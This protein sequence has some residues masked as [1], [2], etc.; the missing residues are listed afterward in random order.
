MFLDDGVW[1]VGIVIVWGFKVYVIIGNLMKWFYD[2]M[3]VN[4]MDE[5]FEMLEWLLWIC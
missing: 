5:D 4:L 3:F 1:G 2:V